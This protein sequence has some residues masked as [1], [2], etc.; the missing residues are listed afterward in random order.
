M[1]KAIME[2][3]NYIFNESKHKPII[4]GLC[5]RARSGKSTLSNKI[6]RQLRKLGVS[7]SFYSADW[8]FKH[9]SKEREKW[10]RES[11]SGDVKK[12]MESVHQNNWWDFER[13]C[14]DLIELKAGNTIHIENAYDRKTGSQSITKKIPSA[15]VIIY[16]SAILGHDEIIQ[17][18]HKLIFLYHPEWECLTTA[19]K[20]DKLRRNAA[21]IASRFLLTTHCENEHYLNL[22]SKYFNQIEVIDRKGTFQKKDIELFQCSYFPIPLENADISKDKTSIFQHDK[23]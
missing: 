8:R 14:N 17:Q 12:Y 4:V 6:V 2:I 19:V 3:A 9:A 13:I 22:F 15:R 7:T 5:G 20:T 16:E 10:L 23:I 21:N 18:L 1:S 11:F